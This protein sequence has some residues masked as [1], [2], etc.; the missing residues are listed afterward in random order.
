MGI[1]ERAAYLR[2]LPAAQYPRSMSSPLDRL[3][4]GLFLWPADV[5]SP[6]GD[7]EAFRAVCAKRF[8]LHAHLIAASCAVFALLF[9]PSDL[10]TLRRLPEAVPVFV[11][12]RLSAAGFS[13]LYMLVP[14]RLVGRHL[15]ALFAVT[16]GAGFFVAGHAFASLGG[17]ELQPI[18]HFCYVV[19]FV[20]TIALPLPIV[21][22]TEPPP[23]SWEAAALAGV[24]LPFPAHLGSP[25]VLMTCTQMSGMIG[26]SL[27][28]G[29][30]LLILLRQNFLQAQELARRAAALA[31][32]GELL[33]G[34]VADR[35]RELRRLLAYVETSTQESERTKIARNRFTT[36]S[37]GSSTGD[38]PCPLVHAHALRDRPGGDRRRPGRTPATCSRARPGARERSS[39]SRLRPPALPR[40]PTGFVAAARWLCGTVAGACSRAS[41]VRGHGLGGRRRAHRPGQRHRRVSHPAGGADQR[42]QARGAR[43]GSR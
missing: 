10:V 17:L 39:Q 1:C 12:W 24:F 3:T 21:A 25:F 14:R 22:R 8:D 43:S 37:A 28:F 38:A 30:V 29:Q 32:H 16:T 23:R 6:G 27:M 7:E 18:V 36:R 4:A 41:R 13:L 33:E 42:R 5:T 26:F 9:W 19:P 11:E 31:S 40:R 34:Q 20:V 35:T 2:R 15:L